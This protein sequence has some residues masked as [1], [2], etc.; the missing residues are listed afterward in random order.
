MP[1]ADT[2]AWHLLL[3]GPAQ[4]VTFGWAALF[5]A[6]SLC[7]AIALRRPNLEGVAFGL[8]SLTGAA[9]L[10]LYVFRA[11]SLP[12][13]WHG[14][15][16]LAFLV[17][18]TLALRLWGLP[19]P[20]PRVRPA[21]SELGLWS[22]VALAFWSVRIIQVN[23]STSLSSQLGWAPL[24]LHSS[25]ADGRFLLPENFSFGTGPVGS[26]FFAVD[27]LGVAA[28]PG[29]LGAEGFY[30]SYLATSILGVGVALLLMLDALRGHVPAQMAFLA[31]L[32]GVLGTDT[33][34]QAAILRHWGDTVLILGGALILHGLCRGQ[35]MVNAL[36]TVIQASAF[37]VLAR[38]YGAVFSALLM[39]GGA[40]A[41]IAT[42]RQEAL[43]LW[44]VWVCAGLLLTAFSL[45]EIY[46]FLNPTPFYPG[47]RLLA[48]VRA[49]AA[50]HVVGAL[51]DW[52][53][54]REGLLAPLNPK[55]FWAY[56][57][58]ALLWLR[59]EQWRRQ[60]YHL[61]VYLAPFTVMLLPLALHAL[62]GYR[63]SG[64]ASKPYLLAVFFAAFVPAFAVYWLVSSNWAA[65]LVK[66]A[67]SGAGMVLLAWALVG[68]WFG[69]G[70][71]RAL[72]LTKNLYDSYNIDRGIWD[73]LA[74]DPRLLEDVASR[75]IMYFYCE[76][77]MG[78]RNYIGGTLVGDRDYW[79]VDVQA[80]L[81]TA[82]DV[83]AWL[84]SQGWPNLYL[85]ATQDYT[86]YLDGARLPPFER[87]MLESQPWVEKVISFRNAQL[88]IVRRPHGAVASPQ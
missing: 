87:E 5:L 70:P 9:D 86:A 42:R 12:A 18:I 57:V 74:A 22:L 33:Q 27:M 58:A 21:W 2:G 71:G 84:S 23:P 13:A 11:L 15:A 47:S 50:F 49:G 72:T 46:F 43:R 34:I 85:S 79:S 51:H 45:R 35:G 52:G 19:E 44:P 62:T 66:T 7:V 56:A 14:A 63:S 3:T 26:L 16:T 1:A 25:F 8:L 82:P 6:L 53:A 60:P 48:Q 37:L 31:V 41:V 80:A 17:P 28:L 29:S 83:E 24:Y 4:A 39:G 20:S 36:R 67:I 78:L 68:G 59:R 77:G 69:V 61:A 76:P 75:R 40:L 73:N 54:M 30:P 10:A 55:F 64:H 81:K 38:H 32:A 65:R 88:V